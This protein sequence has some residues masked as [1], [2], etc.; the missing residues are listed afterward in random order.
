[1]SENLMTIPLCQLKRAALNVRKTGRKA[2]IEQLAASI[3][4]HGLLENLVVRLVR[5]GSEEAEPLYEVVAGGRRFDALKYLAKRHKI[6]MDYPVPCRVLG[7]TEVSTYVEISL[8]EN[9]VRA[10]LHPADQFD[11]FAKLQ[12]EGLTAEEIA[13]RF[14]LPAKV[15][16]QRL[17]LGAVSPRLMA[18]YR[19]DELTLDQL[20]AFA[21]TDDHAAQEAFWFDTPHGHHSPQAIRRH[22]TSALVEGGDRRALFIGAKAY[23]AAGGTVIRDLFQPESE[24]YFA[25]SQLLDRLV[26]EKLDAE[27]G[28]VRAEGWSWVEVMPE[29]DYGA[30]A[31]YGR[32][33]AGEIALSEEDEARLVALSERYDELV[34]ALEDQEDEVMSAEL[35]KIVEEMDSLEERHLEWSDE[36]RKGAGVILS[37]TPEGGL[38]VNAGLIRPEDRKR[39]ETDEEDGQPSQ[40]SARREKSNGR[41]EGYSDALLTDLSA[42]RTAALREMLAG[43]PKVALAALVYRLA[44]PLFFERYASPCLHIQPSFIELG[45]FSKTV[46]ESPAAAALLARHTQWCERLPEADQLWS[47][48]L[49]TEQDALLDLLAYCVALTLD[50]VH[51]K[52]ENP[53]RRM[54]EANDLATALVLDMADWWQPTRSHFFDHLTKGQIIAA[55]S[56]ATSASTA[57]YLTELRKPDMAQRAEELLKD[58]PW[59]PLSLRSEVEEIK[60]EPAANVA[61]E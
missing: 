30:L 52:T 34:A 17:K 9:I 41:P 22:L 27:A 35:D 10:P 56:E 7:E 5:I 50:A 60:P 28:K 36:D 31:K 59:L 24:G 37:L 8:A 19:A 25:D 33:K 11:A 2:D 53:D 49:E 46:G 6:T 20:M 48:L 12:K 54:A 39:E 58:K 51:R 3:E 14:G 43:N 57:K 13:A 29:T 61:A 1:M 40:S 38:E 42:H 32:V 23:E 18:A 4:A 55:V 45:S 21:I 16:V 15:V 44:K 47:W 26:A